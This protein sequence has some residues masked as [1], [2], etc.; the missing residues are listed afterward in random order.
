[1][2]IASKGEI[3]KINNKQKLSLGKPKEFQFY[4]PEE[5][6]ALVE[7]RMIVNNLSIHPIIGAFQIMKSTVYLR[8]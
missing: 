8:F 6:W 2:H 7:R 1:L 3:F 5:Q 4:P